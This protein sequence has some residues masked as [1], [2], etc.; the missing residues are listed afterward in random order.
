[1]T[2]LADF[3]LVDLVDDHEAGDVNILRGGIWRAEYRNVETITATKELADSDCP[4]QLITASGAN[5]TVELA[6]EATTNHFTYIKNAGGSNNVLVKDDSGVTTFATLAPG[7]YAIFISDGAAWKELGGDTTFATSA[8]V[9][10]GTEAA[11]AVSPDT[12][13]DI[14]TRIPRPGMM[15]NGKLSVTVSAND[16]IVAIKTMAG[17]DPAAS[18]PVYINING[19]VRTIT[20]A[21][22]ITLADGTNWMNLGAAEFATIEQDLFIY[23]VWDSNSSIVAVSCARIPGGR[24]VSDFSG[25]STNELHLGNHANFTSTDDV[26]VIGRCAATLSAGAAYTWSVPT[27]TGANLIHEPI[28]E[29]RILTYNPTLTGFSADPTDP[30]EVYQ[31]IRDRVRMIT[32]YATNGTSNATSYTATLPITAKTVTSGQW[33]S[34]H[35]FTDNGSL[36]TSGGRAQVASAASTVTFNTNFG[37]GTWTGS[38]GKRIVMMDWLEYPY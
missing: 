16:L 6:P 11:K 19:T 22:S 13:N 23:A 20:A 9:L 3:D 34:F 32:R 27:F 12:L 7:E 17:A 10:T 14:V 36:S 8:E 24:L 1:M 29:T 18:D 21:T 2:T 38:A 25:T 33:V 35:T 31:I 15:I 5:R 37:G 4:I 30:Y 28:Y 26:C